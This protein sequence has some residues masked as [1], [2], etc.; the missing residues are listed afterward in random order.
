MH[1]QF[2]HS[3]VLKTVE[4]IPILRIASTFYSRSTH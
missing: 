1:N 4:A 2:N 3:K